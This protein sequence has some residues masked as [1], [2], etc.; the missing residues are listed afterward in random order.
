LFDVISSSIK[1]AVNKIRFKDDAAS[2]KKA[3]TELRKSL[4]KADVNHKTTKE[5]VTLVEAE[6][7][8]LGIGQESFLKALSTSLESILTIKVLFILLLLLQPF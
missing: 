3:T 2:L 7:K 6:T 4:L 5:L 8:R 1:N